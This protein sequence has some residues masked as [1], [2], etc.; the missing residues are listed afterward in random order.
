MEEFD[1]IRIVFSRAFKSSMCRGI[2]PGFNMNLLQSLDAQ[3]RD[4]DISGNAMPRHPDF[5]NFWTCTEIVTVHI[6][7]PDES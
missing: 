5:N 4:I 6:L 3:S 7:N 2:C 1:G